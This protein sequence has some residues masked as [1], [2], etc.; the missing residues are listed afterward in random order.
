MC[1]GIRPPQHGKCLGGRGRKIPAVGSQRC[2][3]CR[4]AC[5]VVT[6][7]RMPR[8]RDRGEFPGFATPCRSASPCR[9]HFYVA[10]LQNEGAFPSA[11]DPEWGGGPAIAA[12]SARFT[13]PC[14]RAAI[15]TRF[16]RPTGGFPVDSAAFA[17]R[18][19]PE[20]TRHDGSGGSPN[21][22]HCPSIAGSR[23]GARRD[24]CR[25]RCSRSAAC[26]GVRRKRRA[27]PARSCGP[28]RVAAPEPV[29][30]TAR[31]RR[32]KRSDARSP[33]DGGCGRSTRRRRYGRRH[34]S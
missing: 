10:P 26:L 27:Q 18:M 8:P 32:E 2:S 21:A 30:S 28:S 16:P 20:A 29:G 24:R 11:A 19:H 15:S 6:A 13:E 1:V 4:H 17:G 3:C 14:E 33:G 9:W 5:K 7:S 22:V 23:F 31:A 25:H 12:V 34:R